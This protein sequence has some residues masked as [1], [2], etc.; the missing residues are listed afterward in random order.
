MAAMSPLRV[1]C[2]A[3]GTKIVLPARLCLSPNHEGPV[4]DLLVD[5]DPAREHARTH[6]EALPA[7]LAHF[8]VDY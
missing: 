5:L 8:G 1:A 2:P 3:C 6:A 7:A 4:A